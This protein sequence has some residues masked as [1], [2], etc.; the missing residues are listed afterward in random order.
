MIS[1]FSP[2][3]HTEYSNIRLLDSTNKLEGL[4]KRGIEIGLSGL[5]ITDHESLAG[6]VQIC[7]LQEKYPDF[8][9]AIG[10]EI[11]LVEDRGSGQKYYHFIL[12]AKD[13]EGHRQ[14]RELSSLAW[15]NG[16]TDR[17]LFRVPT[18]KKDLERIIGANPGHVLATTACI[19]GELSQ[20]V[21][22]L[23]DARHVGNKQAEEEIN[24]HIYHFITWC[25]GIFGDNFYIEIAPGASKEQVAA[26]QILYRIARSFNLKVVIGDDAHFLRKEDRFVHKAYLNSTNGEREVDT[27]YQYAYLHSEED[28]INDLT[29]SFNDSTETYYEWFCENSMD[30]FN[31]I[32]TYSLLHNQTIPSVEVKNYDKTYWGSYSYNKNLHIESNKEK[33]PT[34]YSMFQSD[35]KYDRYWVNECVSKLVK[36]HKCNETYLTRLEEEADVKKTI[37]EKLGT[38]IF[39]YPIVLQHYIDMMWDCGSLVGAGR[40]SSCAGLNHNLLGVTQLDPIEWN[41]PFFRYINKERIELPDIDLDLCPS[42]RPLIMKKIKTERGANFDKNMPNELKEELGAT[43]VATFGTETAKSAVQTACRGYRSEEYPDGIDSDIGAYLASLVPVE[44]GFN[45]TIEEMVNG[46]PD[47]GRQPVALFNTEVAKFPGL[48]EIILGIEGLI[49][50]RGIHASGVILFDEDPFEFGCFMKAPNGEV[51]TQYDLHDCEAAGMTKYDFLLTSVQDMLMQTIQFLQ[52][53]G[54]LPQDWTLREIYDE[55]LHPA[56]LNIKDNA[57][58]NNI[59]KGKILSCFQFDSDIGSQGIKKVQPNDILELSNTNGLIRLMAPDGE[60]NPMDK[61]VRFKANP[62]QWDAEMRQYGLTEEEQN[63]FRKYL[64]VSFGVG[65]SQE[66]L[67]KSLMDKDICGF[68]LKD[69]NAA[70][71]IIGKK[72]MSKIPELRAKIKECAKSDAVGRYVWDAIARPQLGYSFSDI[73]ALAYSFIGY[74]TAFIAT[75]WNPIYW[76]TSVLVVNSGSLEETEIYDDDIDEVEIKEKNTDYAK[77]AKAIGE[78]ISHNIKLSLIDINESDY[79]FK[80]DVKNN[81][82]LYGLKALSGVNAEA[83]NQIK[84]NRP[85]ANIIDFMNK[86]KLKKTAMISLIKSGAFDNC[87]GEIFGL[88]DDDKDRIRYANMVYYLMKTSEPKKKL[89]LSNMNGLMQKGIIPD[90]LKYES[91]VYSFHKYLGQHKW[92]D[93]ANN[94]D[95]Y[96]LVPDKAYEFYIE[97]GFNPDY[98][99][100]IDGVPVIEQKAWK[101]NVYDVVMDNVR[102]WLKENQETALKEYNKALFLDEWD[103]YIKKKSLASWEMDSLCFY[104]HE[105]ELKEMDENKYGVVNF[106]N[107]DSEPVVDSWWKR[108]GR[109]IPIY[110]LYRI[111]GTVISKND[112]RHSI[113]LLTNYGVVP[114][115]FNRDMY[116]MYKRQ[117]SEVQEDGTKKITEKGWFTRG[118]MLVINGFRRDDMF[119]AKKYGKTEGHTIYKITNINENGDIVIENERGKKSA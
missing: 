18:L 93:R 12:I 23:I 60:E 35:D 61:Y 78:I 58:W 43:F 56:T 6:S 88:R 13:A 118:T 113:S 117:L 77:I 1:R 116:A 68:G 83:I 92:H 45:W 67:M 107:Y 27:F 41:L 40:G 89:T 85:Y 106:F 49:K 14:L 101:N 75:K 48:L 98:L 57:T 66:Q 7:K 26:N 87:G 73:H 91:T 100:V 5:A 115:K 119:V 21:L 65:I 69:A 111:A 19:G 51:I 10:N 52:E 31:K 97:S 2:H 102:D 82:I 63:A 109:E 25:L 79:G 95:Y 71:K 104:Y 44:R 42:K 62:G 15:V 8:K 90:E 33:Y 24:Q 110:K 99:E 29:P 46:N 80:P 28:C 76:D 3:N 70:R 54:E 16:Y 84:E 30:M 114:V 11:Y 47:K 53:D 32:E 37:S 86:V 112:V 59:K 108:S 39:K 4:V 9:I 55:Y 74:Q 94:R 64:K 96:V 72:Q 36:L 103:K 20:L 17:G 38:N 105:H 34:L 22:G 81:Q 50:S